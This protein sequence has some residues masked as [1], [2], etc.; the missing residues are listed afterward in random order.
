M[1]R[2]SIDALLE[3]I[4][5][6]YTLVVLEGKRA[7]ELREK[8]K[9]TLDFQSVKPTLQALEEIAAGTVTIHPSA[10]IKRE[11]LVQ[12]EKLL[13][14]YRLDEEQRIKAQIAKEQEEEEA[15][16]QEAKQQQSSARS[17]KKAASKSETSEEA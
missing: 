8:E 16:Q 15:K 7:H 10:E 4:D 17:E 3:K 9:A 13:H 14:L 1:L 12:K 11:T 5:S 6:K 2:P